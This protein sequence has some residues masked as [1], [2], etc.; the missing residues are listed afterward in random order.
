MSSP[1]AVFDAS[2]N[3]IKNKHATSLQY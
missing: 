2:I 1:L 3:F